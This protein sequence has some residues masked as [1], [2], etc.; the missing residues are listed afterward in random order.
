MTCVARERDRM[1]VDANA[2]LFV[3]TLQHF[4]VLGKNHG[5]CEVAALAAADAATRTGES[6]GARASSTDTAARAAV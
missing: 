4:R 1:Q 3:I 6:D 5:L 2:P